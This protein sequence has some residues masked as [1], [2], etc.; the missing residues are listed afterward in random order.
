MTAEVSQKVEQK[1]AAQPV[2]TSTAWA[3]GALM[4]TAGLAV[5]AKVAGVVLAPGLR[6]LGSQ[7]TMDFVDT[8]S[9]AL[10]YTL[11]GLLVA[12]LCAG[13]FELAR[14][15]RIGIGARATVVGLS[16]LVVALASPAVITRLHPIAALVLAI[17]T[18]LIVLV[19]GVVASRASHTRAVAA[20]LALL[21]TAGLLRPFAWEASMI[22]G[23]R[24]SPSMFQFGVVLAAV[25][26]IVQALATLLAATWLA[27]R[28]LW[29][30]R[31]L[32]NVAVVLAFVVTYLAARETAGAPSSLD[33][34]LQ[35]AL[36]RTMGVQL[37]Y[38]ISSVAAFLMPASLLLAAVAL[39]QRAQPV[40]VVA[41]LCF[42]LL[43][44][45]SFDVPLQALAIVV[46]AEWLM[47]STAD[48]RSMWS[49]LKSEKAEKTA[50]RSG[51]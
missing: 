3:A 2:T 4:I 29:R 21:A 16:G 8:G 49:S 37:P 43:S 11:A 40:A 6:G 39:L 27:T 14:V 30:G 35:A 20:I 23:E 28:S 36:G 12:L 50:Q 13:S 46:A 34:A 48:D 42:A 32:A 7:K 45:G 33:S 51:V 15:R 44:G 9:A 38:G 10:A 18:S 31:V 22:G 41:A 5:V 17:I 25:A 24:A 19:A 1:S 47:L 26:V